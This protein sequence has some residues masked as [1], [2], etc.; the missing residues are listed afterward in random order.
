MKTKFLNKISTNGISTTYVIIYMYIKHM[1]HGQR[2]F[3]PGMQGRFSIQKPDSIIHHSNRVNRKN[4]VIAVNAEKVFD[5]FNTH[6][7]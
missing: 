4:H 2:E 6:M 1:H 3:V 5:K 7:F